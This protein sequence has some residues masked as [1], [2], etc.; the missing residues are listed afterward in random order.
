MKRTTKCLHIRQRFARSDES[1]CLIPINKNSVM[2]QL[3]GVGN[4]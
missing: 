4:K 3:S 1:Q 2:Q